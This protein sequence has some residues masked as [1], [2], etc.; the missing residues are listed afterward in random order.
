MLVAGMEINCYM[1]FDHIANPH[2]K[3]CH[4]FGVEKRNIIIIQ[5]DDLQIIN[6]KVNS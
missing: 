5:N 6:T 1:L 3:P 4:Q 2:H